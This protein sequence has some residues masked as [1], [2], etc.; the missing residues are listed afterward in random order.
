MNI[1]FLLQFLFAIFLLNVDIFMLCLDFQR[2]FLL[3][4]SLQQQIWNQT[5]PLTSHSCSR[6][7]CVI[8]M[9]R[10]RTLAFWVNLI[11]LAN[12]SLGEYRLRPL[13]CY[14]TLGTVHSYSFPL[15]PNIKLCIVMWRSSGPF[16]FSRLWGGT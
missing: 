10:E 14:Y 4:N 8:L 3:C 2:T 15:L 9:H 5:A 1:N 16:C 7:A 12:I 11:Y 6:L 13:L